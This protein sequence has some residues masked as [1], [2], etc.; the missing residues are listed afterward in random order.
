VSYFRLE[1][2]LPNPDQS[3]EDQPAEAVLAM[4]L[5]GEARGS[6]IRAKV[7]VASVILNRSGA[8]PGRFFHKDLAG[9]GHL[10]RVKGVVLRPYQFSCF[11]VNDPNRAQLLRPTHNDSVSV[12]EEC[13]WV[14][15]GAID[16]LFRDP[17]FGSDHYFSPVFDRQYSVLNEPAWAKGKTPTV[18]MRGF[19]FYRIG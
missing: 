13:M 17:T 8:K 1:S 2:F 15:A 9:A 3:I 19:Y 11:N 4:C 6:D 18:T 14:A 7:S 10:A 5:W 16:G 12:W